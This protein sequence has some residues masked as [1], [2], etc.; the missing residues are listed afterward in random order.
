VVT[1]TVQIRLEVVQVRLA[2]DKLFRLVE[3]VAS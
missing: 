3:T 2:V 1:K